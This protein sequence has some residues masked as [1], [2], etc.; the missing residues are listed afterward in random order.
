[1]K[2]GLIGRKLG[3]S[4]S[5]EIHRQFLSAMGKEGSYDLL[6]TEPENLE[7]LMEKCKKEYT[8]VNVTIPYKKAVIPF[9]DAVDPPAARIGAVNTISFSGGRAVGYNTDYTGFGCSLRHCGIVPEKKKCTV[10][11][12]GGAA[13]A[14][15]CFLLDAGAEEVRVVSRNPEKAG[16]DILK[17]AGSGQIILEDYTELG[18]HGTGDILINCTPVGMFP[19]AEASPVS[20]EVT[21]RFRA[22]ADLI[23]NPK[24]TLFLSYAEKS[25]LPHLNGLCMLVMQAAAAEEIWQQA[26]IS[27]ELAESVIGEMENFL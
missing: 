25:G 9:L 27:K 13:L 8:G 24:Q 15:I 16:K 12:T 21:A 3:H 26:K 17:K 5:P 4:L 10:L 1:M 7:R 23:Y 18:T 6:E 19:N 2:L 20:E 22:A 11:G 14:V